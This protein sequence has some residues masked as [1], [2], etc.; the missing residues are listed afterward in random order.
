MLMKSQFTAHVA[1]KLVNVYFGLYL[2]LIYR[3]KL[4]L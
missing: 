2:T 4:T 3:L 1:N